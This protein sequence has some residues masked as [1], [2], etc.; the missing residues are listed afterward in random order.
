MVELCFFYG[1]NQG[2]KSSLSQCN[3]FHFIADLFVKPHPTLTSFGPPSLKRDGISSKVRD[4]FVLESDTLP[5]YGESNVRET[6]GVIIDF[7]NQ[8][9]T[10]EQFVHKGLQSELMTPYFQQMV[11]ELL[12]IGQLIFY[13]IVEYLVLFSKKIY[14]Q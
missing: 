2:F 5:F 4:F 11:F 1:L 14:G 3:K 8:K 10:S 13:H 7:R 9:N 6:F 12:Y